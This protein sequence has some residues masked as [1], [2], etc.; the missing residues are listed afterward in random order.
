[1]F[2]FGA[3]L[4]GGGISLFMKRIARQTKSISVEL[5]KSNAQFS[6]LLIQLIQNF[7]YLKTTGRNENYE[8]KLYANIVKLKNLLVSLGIRKSLSLSIREPASIIIVCLIIMIQVRYFNNPISTVI[9]S[10]L[11]FYRA[12]SEIIQLQANWQIFIG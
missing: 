4:S 6:G 9:V 11:L 10:L 5:S 1:V 8:N 3:L 2:T 7:K 12:L